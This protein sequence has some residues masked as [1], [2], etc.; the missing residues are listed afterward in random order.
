ME[1][2]SRIENPGDEEDGEYKKNSV[3]YIGVAGS[4]GVTHIAGADQLMLSKQK[5]IELNSKY[6]VIPIQHGILRAYFHRLEL[7]AT[8]SLLWPYFP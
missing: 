6:G 1:D 5:G 7:L 4:A 2:A 8:L 3:R